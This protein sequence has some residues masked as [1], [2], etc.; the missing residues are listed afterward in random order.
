ME[1]QISRPLTYSI[2][3]RFSPGSYRIKH[4]ILQEIFVSRDTFIFYFS[5]N[6]GYLRGLF[7]TI[8]LFFILLEVNRVTRLFG[9][10]LV[11]YPCHP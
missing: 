5:L 7:H 10:F 11:E 9:R 4:V 1:S 6:I 8:S 3:I 2:V